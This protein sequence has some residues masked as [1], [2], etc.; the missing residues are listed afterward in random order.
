MSKVNLTKKFIDKLPTPEGKRV[1]VYDSQTRGLGV[2]VTPTGHRSFFWF[3]KVAG[4]PTWRTIG[5]YPDL[6]IEQARA[7]A[8]EYN[9]N[10]AEWKAK[11]YEGASPFERRRELTLSAALEEYIEKHLKA[12][13]QNPDRAVKDTRWQIDKYAASLKNRNLSSIRREHLRS[14]HA[15]IGDKNGKFTANRLL[16]TI[17]AIFNHALRTELWSGQNP[18]AGISPF[19]EESRSRFLQP[20]EFPKFL[21]TLTSEK[22]IDLRDL[23]LL[24]VFTGARRQN[25][26]AMRWAELDLKRGMWNIPLTKNG[27]PHIVPL[28]TEATKIL[29]DR[30]RSR[31][32]DG[33]VFP[34]PVSESGHLENP[35]RAWAQFRKR[36]GIADV[37]LHDLR[38]TLG[39]WEAG[40]GVPLLTIAKTLGHQSTDA[41]QVYSRLHLEPVRLAVESATG[42]MIAA[43]K[44]VKGSVTEIVGGAPCINQPKRNRGPD[45]RRCSLRCAAPVP[46]QMANLL[47]TPCSA[48][49]FRTAPLFRFGPP[50][51]AETRRP[52]H[53]NA[54][55]TRAQS[56]SDR[57]GRPEN[58]RRAKVYRG[59]E[60]P[61][62][63]ET[64]LARCRR[65]HGRVFRDNHE[66]RLV[67]A[68]WPAIPNP[69]RVR[70]D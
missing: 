4:Y 7:K 16:Q 61:T 56:A 50:G 35:K 55:A 20:N 18:A 3:R 23:V 47:P 45:I 38:R 15:G 29:A 2:M 54:D 58:Y 59:R 11:E 66:R 5:Q 17:R 31:N 33:W 44:A 19:H 25:L 21:K 26:L 8:S 22:N 64:L 53:A 27:E 68:Q 52:S 62:S 70:S 1:L 63:R 36:A 37:R 60:I 42:A 12:K 67:G 49:V 48:S 57:Q 69:W 24:A 6:S 28:T 14:L 9:T 40:S 32:G 51:I 13:A 65:T 46:N 41:T 43:G 30:Q 34:S 39:S 10:T